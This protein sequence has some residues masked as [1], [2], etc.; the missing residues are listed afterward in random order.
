[1]TADVCVY[2]GTPAGC[3]AAVA[4]AREG[5]SVVLV[6]PSRW[7]G[8]M[9]GAGI[10]PLQ[11]CPLPDA[12]GGLT[13][14][15]VLA[16]GEDPRAIP[17]AFH[18]WVRDAGVDVRFE[19]RVRTVTMAGQRVEAIRLET[20]APDAWGVPLPASEA[21]AAEDVRARVFV[22]ASYEGDLMAA[23]GV[24]YR[25]GRE[26][27]TAFGEAP[28]GVGEV[29]NWTPVDPYVVPGDATSGLLPFIDD[30]HGRAIGAADEFTQ[31]YNFRFYVTTD[32]A[33]REPLTP[34]EGYRPERFELVRRYVRH[35]VAAE[36][37]P[38]ALAGRLRG[39]FPGWLN[40]GEYNYQ[41]D[42]LVTIAPLGVSR[43][44]QDGNWDVRSAIWREHIDYLRGL[45]HVLSTAP[46][47]PAWFRAETAAIGLDRDVFPATS[48]WPHQLYVRVARR[49]AGAYTLTHADVLN[50]TSVADA[51]GLAL[52]GVDTYPAR[53][54][55][56]RG[57]GGEGMGVATEG[58]MFIGGHL[59]TGVPY[60][61]P[62]RAL[63]PRPGDCANLLV[64][65]CLSATHIAYAATRMEP[66]FCV[67]GESAGVAA[68]MAL[69]AGAP[70][71]D[72]DVEGLRD[73]L[74]ELGQVLS[75]P[76]A[77]R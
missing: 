2:G 58:N 73:R 75:W 20:S 70:V 14:D 27:R 4:V 33:R 10:K 45:H 15:V 34:P 1:M 8:G 40:S 19:R 62:Y 48:G 50:R 12:A 66:V 44:Y 36:R 35:L 46:E 21:V 52:F 9:L 42:A 60:P 47:V 32:P 74:R 26:A 57:P 71:Q 30:D 16:M 56:R 67:L 28:A 38:A 49:L 68:V 17:S 61:V 53:R 7:L 41:R 6:E 76:P 65:V 77:A 69:R 22:D 23:A 18:R 25:T 3:V 13:R 39:I 37:D 72:V 55:A 59:G 31:A 54:I 51:V 64:P 43:E 29:T 63:T 11:D 24:P 5:A